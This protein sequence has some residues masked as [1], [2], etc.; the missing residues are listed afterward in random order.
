M[1]DGL[2][3]KNLFFINNEL[4]KFASENNYYFIPLDEILSMEKKDYFDTAHTTPQGSKRIADTI[5]PVL[6]EFFKI[7]NEITK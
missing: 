4:K 1:Y 5:F 3:D 6:L 2:K 7:N